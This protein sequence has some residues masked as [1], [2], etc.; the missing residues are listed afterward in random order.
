MC[1]FRY[2]KIPDIILSLVSS[3]ILDWTHIFYT[4]RTLDYLVRKHLYK[5]IMYSKAV[6]FNQTQRQTTNLDIIDGV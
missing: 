4:H 6:N 5:L 2:L 3:K 1:M